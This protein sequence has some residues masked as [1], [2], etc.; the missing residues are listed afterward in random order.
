M[1][2]HILLMGLPGAGKTTVGKLLA[3]RL[4]TSLVDT[5]A[6]LVRRM[7]M[8]VTQ[9]FA[10]FGEPKFRSLEVE[11]L[12]QAVAGPP[13]VIA[14][15]GG[16]VVSPGAFEAVRPA[17]FLVYLRTMVLTAAKR[18]GGEA[19]RPL[20]VGEDPVERMRQLLKQREPYYAQADTELKADVKAPAALADEI[21]ILARERAGW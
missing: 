17:C 5:D 6:I 16:W 14:P 7:Q 2:R 9:I 11:V 10:E 8:P 20:L 13:S 1:K 4:G 12:T 18:A 15:G 3:E 21:A 19:T